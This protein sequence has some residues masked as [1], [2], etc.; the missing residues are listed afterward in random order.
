M[1]FMADFKNDETAIVL[2]LQREQADICDGKWMQSRY[3]CDD[4]DRVRDFLSFNSVS[5]INP[6]EVG[7]IACSRRVQSSSES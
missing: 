7:V 1:S 5:G 6:F 2:D 3:Y 4:G